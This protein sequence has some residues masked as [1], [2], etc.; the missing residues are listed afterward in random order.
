MGSIFLY[1][2]NQSVGEGV[3]NTGLLDSCPGCPPGGFI[4]SS[5]WFKIVFL[6]ILMVNKSHLLKENLF[7]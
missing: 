4:C 6:M 3:P 1:F 2:V 5:G 7:F